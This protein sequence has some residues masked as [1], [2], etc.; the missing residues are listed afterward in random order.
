MD[1]RVKKTK[2]II[3]R[4]MIKFLKEKPIEQI[5][6]T[7]ICKEAE[8]N[9]STYYTYF[10]NPCDQLEKMTDEFVDGIIK[11]ISIPGCSDSKKFD[12]SLATNLCKYFYDNRE[13][14]LAVSREKG[15]IFFN[16]QQMERLKKWSFE[17]W[18]T[19]IGTISEREAEYL[20][21]FSVGGS[22]SILNNWLEN[23]TEYSKDE[24]AGKIL[25]EYLTLGFSKFRSK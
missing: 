11:T 6:V 24:E 19:K 14:Y 21:A 17:Y 15:C 8:I 1:K 22:V 18:K 20:F 25:L 7:D 12:P 9:R 23:G 3:K 2:Q 16:M 4:A 5:T 13:F 10:D